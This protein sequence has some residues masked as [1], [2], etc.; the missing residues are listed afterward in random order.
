MV[1]II[2][3]YHNEGEEFINETLQS[4]KNTIDIP[5]EVIIV[6][7]CSE[8][9]LSIA[10]IRHDKNKGVGS[11]F[12]TGVKL[13]KYDYIFLMGCDIRF[14]SN[15]YASKMINT[16]KDYPEALVCTTCVNYKPGVSF[17]KSTKYYGAD[18]IDIL[19]PP[20]YNY[21]TIL[22]AKWKLKRELFEPYDI[23]C[24]LGAFY[25]VKKEFYN[26]IDGFWGHKQWGTL[27]PYISIKARKFGGRVVINPEIETGH[28]FKTRDTNFHRIDFGNVIYNKL[29]VLELLYE[30]KEKERLYNSIPNSKLKERALKLLSTVDYKSKREEYNIL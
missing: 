13:A 12:D 7:D 29:L 16:L 2:I 28:I 17:E 1:S 5:Y 24:I 22:E 11:A 8:K 14:E 6:D 15:N 9:P 27:E 20:E 26:R 30:G 21:R 23:P 3:P 18:I 10:T 4:I 25:G 19:T